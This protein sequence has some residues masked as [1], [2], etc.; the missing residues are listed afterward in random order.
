MSR[1]PALVLAVVLLLIEGV[2][3]VGVGL[4]LLGGMLSAA[5][6]DAGT[7]IAVGMAGYGAALAAA[8]LA[9]LARRRWGWMLGVVATAIGLVFLIGLLVVA[10]SA[11]AVLVGGVGIWGITLAALVVGRRA[12]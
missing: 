12:A 5:G 10:G 1:S 3:G 4:T 2:S 9:L 7:A 11:D 8:G 6:A